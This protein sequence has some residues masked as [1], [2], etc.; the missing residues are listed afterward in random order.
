MNTILQ[1]S[2]SEEDETDSPPTSSESRIKYY[3]DTD[4]SPSVTPKSK[5]SSKGSKETVTESTRAVVSTSK[6]ETVVHKPIDRPSSADKFDHSVDGRRGPDAYR[7]SALS[8]M[9]PEH[10]A[11]RN[12]KDKQNR[13]T[14]VGQYHFILSSCISGRFNGNSLAE[15]TIDDGSINILMM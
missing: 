9:S 7:E 1:D 4:N 14:Q 8:C 13:E 5:L 15:M 3:L 2:E 11:L 6:S 12:L 10:V